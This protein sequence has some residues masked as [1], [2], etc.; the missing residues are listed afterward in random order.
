MGG[1]ARFPSTLAAY[2]KLNES[3]H[4]QSGRLDRKKGAS[5]PLHNAAVTALHNWAGSLL[6]V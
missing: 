2:Q 5:L 3:E 1:F 4:Q 6:F